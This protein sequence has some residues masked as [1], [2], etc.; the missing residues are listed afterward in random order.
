M[1]PRVKLLSLIAGAALLVSVLLIVATQIR[2]ARPPGP[3]DV[4]DAA[5]GPGQGI[6]EFRRARTDRSGR[7]SRAVQTDGFERRFGFDGRSAR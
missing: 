4:E 3:P 6:P 2:R 1:N 7:K 5:V